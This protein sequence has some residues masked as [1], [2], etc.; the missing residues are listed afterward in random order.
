DHLELPWLEASEQSSEHVLRL[1]ATFG[2]RDE[3]AGRLRAEIDL[4]GPDVDGDAAEVAL[5]LAK[6]DGR[7]PGLD[8]ARRVVGQEPAV[9][10]DEAYLDEL[11]KMLRE[12]AP[13]EQGPEIAGIELVELLEGQRHTR[14]GRGRGTGRLGRARSHTLS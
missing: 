11:V 4:L 5:M 6:D 1:D 3:L 9:D 10:L 12:D 13:H 8:R 2:A 14:R 7:D